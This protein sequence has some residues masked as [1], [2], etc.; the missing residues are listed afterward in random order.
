MNRLRTLRAAA[1]LARAALVLSL[2][3]SAGCDHP[4]DDALLTPQYSSSGTPDVNRIAVY[5]GG[6]PGLTI[7]WA[8]AW[9]GPQGGSVR[10]LDFEIIVPPGAVSKTTKFEIRLPVDPKAAE[11]ALAEFT[12]HNTPFAQPVTIRLPYRGTS[13]EDLTSSV[14]WWNGAAWER[15][16]TTLLPDG[17]L[18]TTT[19][20]FSTYGTEEPSRGITPLGG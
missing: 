1:G 4:G 8:K 5:D 7:A 12:P 15:Y 13:A 14:L 11:H 9:I 17:R 10:L 6:A 16:P 20:H 3:L 18:E 2:A 19:T